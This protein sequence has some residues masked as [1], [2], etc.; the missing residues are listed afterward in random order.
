MPGLPW[1]FSGKQHDRNAGEAGSIS[2][3]GRSS[4]EENGNPLQSSSLENPMERGAWRA[5]VHGVAKSWTRLK[6]IKPPTTYQLYTK[7]QH[8]KYLPRIRLVLC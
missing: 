5:T 3:F 4:G 7:Q 1:W 8:P 2:G 6:E